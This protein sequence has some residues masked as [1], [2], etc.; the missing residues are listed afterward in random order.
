[1]HAV[2]RAFTPSARALARAHLRAV[3]A[4]AETTVDS[5][6]IGGEERE[7]RLLDAWREAHWALRVR[8][9]EARTGGPVDDLEA[10]YEAARH[11]DTA[12]ATLYQSRADMLARQLRDQSAAREREGARQARPP[13]RSDAL[14]IAERALILRYRT[15]AAEDRQALLRL[16]VRLA[17]SQV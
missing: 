15:M 6:T 5:G 16:A 4:P 2:V 9:R 8:L 11:A 13:S 10:L 3:T 7:R 17:V 1:M 14:S 12:L